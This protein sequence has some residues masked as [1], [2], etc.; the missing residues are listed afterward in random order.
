MHKLPERW[1]RPKESLLQ[2]SRH[3]SGQLV[4]KVNVLLS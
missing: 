1:C 3:T 2:A 4:K